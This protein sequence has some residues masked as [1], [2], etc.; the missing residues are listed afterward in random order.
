M[1]F[2]VGLFCVAILC[3]ALLI[4]ISFAL[5]KKR[6]DSDYSIKNSFPFELNYNSEIKENI[7]THVF[8]ALFVVVTCGFYVLYETSYS[9]GILLIAV[10][11]GT[12]ATLAIYSLFYISLYRY[13][14]HI[15]VA[16]IA[17]ALTLGA[18]SSSVVI[19]IRMVNQMIKV[20]TVISLVISSCLALAILF[21]IFNPRL[22]GDIRKMEV[23]K[24][25]GEVEYV[26]PKWIALAFSEWLLIIINILNMLSLLILK[27]GM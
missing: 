13:K 17:V 27:F 8:L 7:Y 16:S 10:I 9:D 12:L 23:A 14:M 19:A 26:R 25:N 3:F 24:D 20:T 11:G 5:Y 6:N 22:T 2:S 21:I 15:V 4:T 18:V 1:I